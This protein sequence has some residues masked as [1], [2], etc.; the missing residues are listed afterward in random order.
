MVWVVELQ[1]EARRRLEAGEAD[2]WDQL[3]ALFEG[4][5]ITTALDVT[6]GRRIEA[7]VKLGIGRNTLTRK[8]KELELKV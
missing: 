8:I 1:R 3:T 5:L 4:C 6:H 7:A 2:V